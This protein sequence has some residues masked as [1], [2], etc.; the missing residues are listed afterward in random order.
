MSIEYY[1]TEFQV[2]GYVVDIESEEETKGL[3]RYVLE[4][5]KDIHILVMT[6]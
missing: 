2:H 1:H 5:V 3:A 6:Q 4:V